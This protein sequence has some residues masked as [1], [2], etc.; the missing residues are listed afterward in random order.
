MRATLFAIALLLQTT[1]APDLAGTWTLDTYVSDNPEQVLA[2][3][4]TDLGQQSSGTFSDAS[5][6]APF[7]RSRG[8]RT[9]TRPSQTKKPSTE[10][11]D[12]QRAL[13]NITAAIRY[14]PPTLKISQTATAVTLAEPQGPSRTFD[15][16]GKRE[17][18]SFDSTR[19]ET[20]ASWQGP[21]LVIAYDLGKG[22][23]MTCTYSIVPT[24]RQLSLRVTIEHAPNQP[25]PFEVKL[26]YDRASA[27]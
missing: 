20:T 17:M 25:G 3:I 2:S 15:T 9:E 27:G 8:R 18:Q 6:T 21:Q 26:F 13:D 14:P 23:K 5:D 4:R 10:D 11:A 7:G 12:D 22:R 24:T 19:A 16:S 1:G